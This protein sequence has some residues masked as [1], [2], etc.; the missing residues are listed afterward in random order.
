MIITLKLDTASHL[1][2]AELRKKFYPAYCNYVDAHVSLFHHVKADADVIES[3]V[4]T[5]ALH[6]P[7]KLSV[8]GVCNF[9]KGVAYEIVS[10]ELMSLHQQM[11]AMLAPYLISKDRKTFRPHITVQ[12]RV[13][14]FK[15]SQTAAALCAQFS[16]YEIRAMGLSVWTFERGP[17][18]HVRD[19]LFS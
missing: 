6:H 9:K 8:T 19:I 14:A 18:K 5:L 4:K 12:N 3:C 16:P 17:W 15:A 2:F 13:T 7:I 11:Q 10:E 1:H